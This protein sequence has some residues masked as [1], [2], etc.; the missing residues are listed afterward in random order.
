M[1]SG[2]EQPGRLLCIR[3]VVVEDVV[4]TSKERPIKNIGVVGGGE[5]QAVRAVL[6][7][8]QQEAVEHATDLAD[9]VGEFPA[10]ADGV[11][12]VEEVD[13]ARSVRGVEDLSQFGGGLAHEA[14]DEAVEA[15][16]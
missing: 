16:L 7:D 4:E 1:K 11:E 6:L 9:V 15:D 8:H 12:F 3:K 13:A 5:H 2:A 14:R 10:G